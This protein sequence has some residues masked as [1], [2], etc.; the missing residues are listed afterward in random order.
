LGNII[1][2]LKE[3]RQEEDSWYHW[4]W[5]LIRDTGQLVLAGLPIVVRTIRQYRGYYRIAKALQCSVLAHPEP[6]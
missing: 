5:Y 1:F 2:S 6:N 3:I 4:L